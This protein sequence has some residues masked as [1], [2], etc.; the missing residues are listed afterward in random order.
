MR[1]NY[2]LAQ[3]SSL[4][5]EVVELRD[6]IARRDETINDLIAE[7]ERLLRENAEADAAYDELNSEVIA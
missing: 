5:G 3:V 1:L 4:T 2:A 7:N 6:R